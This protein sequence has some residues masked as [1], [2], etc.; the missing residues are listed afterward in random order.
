MTEYEWAIM[1]NGKEIGTIPLDD[2]ADCEQ[3]A[4][5]NWANENLEARICRKR[6]AEKP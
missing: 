1:H 2:N 5:L 6:E 4:K 3:D